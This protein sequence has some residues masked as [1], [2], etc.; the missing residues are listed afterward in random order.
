MVVPDV[1]KGHS[2]YVFMVKQSGLLD[3]R[4]YSPSDTASPGRPFVSCT[5]V[6][7]SQGARTRTLVVSMRHDVTRCS[8]LY[9]FTSVSAGK[10]R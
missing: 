2:A 6:T 7:T 10:L 1:S 3:S 4:K 5:S 8:S 9:T